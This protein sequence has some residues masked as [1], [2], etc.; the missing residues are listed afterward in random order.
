MLFLYIF[1]S[2]ILLIVF[3]QPLPQKMQH[4]YLR[5][6]LVIKCCVQWDGFQGLGLVEI[7][8]E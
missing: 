2:S 7:A 4:Q 1:I 8:M 3:T 6:M 5:Q